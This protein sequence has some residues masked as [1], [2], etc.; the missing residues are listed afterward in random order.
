MLSLRGKCLRGAVCKYAHDPR[1]SSPAPPT[2]AYAEPFVGGA[3][4]LPCLS[5]PPP[6]HLPPKT[7]EPESLHAAHM[8]A[9]QQQQ[10]MYA[11]RAAHAQTG[12]CVASWLPT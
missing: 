4:G 9:I 6:P 3:A 2:G 5:V 1:V 11:S 12:R 7:T 10:L 8:A